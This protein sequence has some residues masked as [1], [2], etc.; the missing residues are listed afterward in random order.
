M[1]SKSEHYWWMIK[2]AFDMLVEPFDCVEFYSKP[3]KTYHQFNENN[4]RGVREIA[5][6]ELIGRIGYNDSLMFDTHN[7]HSHLLQVTKDADVF[8]YQ[9]N[10]PVNKPHGVTWIDLD[11]VCFIKIKKPSHTNKKGGIFK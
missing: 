3:Y 5:H 9:L 7:P 8:N 4:K 6:H 11:N 2:E 10:D 1:K